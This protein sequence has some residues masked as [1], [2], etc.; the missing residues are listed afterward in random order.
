MKT[1]Y[2]SKIIIRMFSWILVVL[3]L[4]CLTAC[5]GEGNIDRTASFS[6]DTV[7]LAVSDDTAQHSELKFGTTEHCTVVNTV[8]KNSFI[9]PV[10]YEYNGGIVKINLAYTGLPVIAVDSYKDTYEFKNGTVLFDVNLED[11]IKYFEVDKNG[12]IVKIHDSYPYRLESSPSDIDPS[13]IG[14][15]IRCGDGMYAYYGDDESLLGLMDSS[16][17][18]LTEPIFK[19]FFNFY[20]GYASAT[21]ANDGSAVVIDKT[22]KIVGALPEQGTSYGDGVIA[23]MSGEPGS[24]VF[25]IYNVCGELLCEEGFDNITYFNDGIA[26]IVKNNKIGFIDAEGNIIFEPTIAFDEIVYPPKDKG[27]YLSFMCEDA[28]VVPIGGEFAVISIERQ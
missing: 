27:F 14:A 8:S 22:G 2:K 24:Y 7:G 3:L 15:D 21:L 13:D 25:H 26:A 6:D 12:K 19:A 18:K 1:E 11:G 23:V 17:N 16:G 4:F 9:D 20:Q 5:G 28:L 10:I